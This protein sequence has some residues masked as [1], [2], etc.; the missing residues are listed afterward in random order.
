M[1]NE[2]YLVEVLCCFYGGVEVN[3][4]VIF[5]LNR[6]VG[7]SGEWREEEA[8]RRTYGRPRR[9]PTAARW[10]CHTHVR[11]WK[12]EGKIWPDHLWVHLFFS[13]EKPKVQGC[14]FLT[15]SKNALIQQLANQQIWPLSISEADMYIYVR[16][17][18]ATCLNMHL[19][20]EHQFTNN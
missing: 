5:N 10:L 18:L 7:W 11:T 15:I 20:S 17:E 12:E 6:Q 16:C 1:I 2:W 4:T 9:L 8:W 3:W 13:E 14:F 19:N